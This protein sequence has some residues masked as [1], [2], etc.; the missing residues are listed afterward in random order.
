MSLDPGVVGMWTGIIGAASGLGA[1][2]VSIWNYRR[3]SA[4]KSLD[5]RLELRR[6]LEDHALLQD[7]IEGF[8]DRVH[9]AHRRVLAAQG[10][11]G[12]GQEQIWNRE[13]REDKEELARLLEDA[14]RPCDSYRT[15]SP[16]KLADEL[17]AVHRSSGKL[18][19]LRD[20]YDNVLQKD[21]EWRA[22]REHRMNSRPPITPTR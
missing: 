19:A 20:K 16:S 14:P 18:K 1:L 10:Q 21:D 17:V 6:A 5:L 22:M 3:V 15:F 2:A 7:G 4:I 9:E 12:G 8:L 13:F 11:I